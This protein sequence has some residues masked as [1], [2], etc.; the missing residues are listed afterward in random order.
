MP[1]SPTRILEARRRYGLAA[2]SVLLLVLVVVDAVLNPG[3]WILPG[4][5]PL[6]P[7]PAT[8]AFVQSVITLLVLMSFSLSWWPLPILWEDAQGQVWG[9]RPWWRTPVRLDPASIRAQ[10]FFLEATSVAGAQYRWHL[11]RVALRADLA[12]WTSPKAVPAA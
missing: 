1:L 3:P 10:G 4:L 6:W 2:W 5:Q 11:R 7:R 12:A 9:Y 8:Y